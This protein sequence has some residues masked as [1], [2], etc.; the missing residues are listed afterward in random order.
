MGGLRIAFR[1]EMRTFLLFGK[2]ASIT[3]IDYWMRIK[4]FSKHTASHQWCI[5]FC[6]QAP[7]IHPQH[8]SLFGSNRGHGLVN[9]VGM[10]GHWQKLQ[11]RM[12][13]SGQALD[14]PNP[15]QMVGSSLKHPAPG[16]CRPILASEASLPTR[17]QTPKCYETCQIKFT[18]GL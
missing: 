1:I 16:L 8:L 2:T 5:L 3:E 7:W 18:L 12:F 11:R 14:D 10:C 4:E 17:D 6:D 15:K 13:P 9:Y